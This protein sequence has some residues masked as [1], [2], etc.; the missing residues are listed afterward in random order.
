MIAAPE[1][2]AVDAGADVLARGGNAIDAAVTCAFVEG[3]V[4]PHDTSIG[5]FALLN[6]Q[7]AGDPP[8]S[9]RILDA[10]ATA[11]ALTAPDMWASAYLGPNPGGWGFRL[12][13][14]VNESG[15][16]S[17]ATP[18]AVR[19]LATMLERWGTISL[20][21][22]IAPAA[23]IAD[24]GFRVDHRIATYWQSPSPYPGMPHLLDDLRAN[25]EGARV[26]LRPDGSP[27]QTNDTI[28]NPDYARTLRQLAERG[29]DDFYTGDLA[30][31]MTE[32]F[33]RNGGFVTP[34]DLAGYRVRDGRPTS[35]TYRGFTIETA[36]APHCGPTLLEILNIVEGWEVG[37]LGHNSA[38]YVLR[39]GLAMKAAFVDRSRSLGDPAFVDPRVEWM[40]SKERAAE[41]RARIDH[42]AEIGPEADAEPAAAE[43]PGTTHVSVVDA[44]GNCVAL[45]HSL[46]GSSGVVSPGL[47]F[48][49][50]NSMINFHP[51][52]GH[53]NS[54][55]P[56]KGRI[57]GMTPTIVSRDGKPV[58]VIGAPG[59]TRIVTA[60]AQ[61]IVNHLDFG[62]S[63][64]EAI[65][66]PRF[67]CQGGP[68]AFQS[69]IPGAIVAEVA[70]RHPADRTA[71]GHGG[72][73]FVHAIAIDPAT[74]ALTGGADT[75]AA[76]MAIGV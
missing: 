49:Y 72:F 39:F 41:W 56:G 57:T 32:D 45:T 71:V 66:A 42:G 25:R 5:G 64:Q 63:I 20:A 35:G 65:L 40:T 10:P 54:I 9:A 53:P 24:E 76:G 44:A 59:A 7:L 1:P 21:E 19:G 2:L 50:N 13:G 15:Y 67:D 3:V 34:D 28:R 33:A 75:G 23:R 55:A 14:R 29:A 70:K 52:P 8:A 73:A 16:R 61:V 11:G 69:R 27:H 26:F 31:R 47:G 30:R 12:Q 22:A 37:A 68:I 48:M 74:R 43:A 60:I 6:V 38:E 62:M 17:I 58:L 46:G 36:P 4:D 18:G 51:L